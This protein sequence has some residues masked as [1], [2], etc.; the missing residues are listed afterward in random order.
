MATSGN[1][2]GAGMMMETGG[3][4]LNRILCGISIAMLCAAFVASPVLA[5]EVSKTSQF[6]F[7]QRGSK[8]EIGTFRDRPLEDDY[9]GNYADVCPV[10]ALTSKD[11]RFNSRVWFLERTDSV[12]PHCSTGTVEARRDSDGSYLQCLSCS[13][14]LYAPRYGRIDVSNTPV[15]VKAKSG[16]EESIDNPSQ[17][18]A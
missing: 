2:S 16:P 10:G 6:G 5:D 8:M 7:F 12:C 9:A 18:A 14:T 17:E 1:E 3:R 4:V 15:P 13:W 11:F